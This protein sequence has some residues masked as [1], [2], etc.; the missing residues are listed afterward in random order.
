[1][2][3]QLERREDDVEVGGP[4]PVL[5]PVGQD[6]LLVRMA[7]PIMLVGSGPT[8]RV[9]L[10]GEKVSTVHAA[11]IRDGTIAYVR[12]LASRDGVMVD[13]ESVQECLLSGGE[14]LSVGGFDF[15]FEGVSAGP[16]PPRAPE[17]TL[18]ETVIEGR[19]LLIGH[20]KTCDVVVRGDAGVSTAHALI[21][22][23]SG[24]RYIRDLGSRTGT[25]V[26]GKRVHFEGL[27]HGDVI[28]VGD[29]ELMYG[30]AE[31]LRFQDV[32]EISQTE[33]ATGPLK[34]STTQAGLEGVASDLA[35]VE[36][37]EGV[38]DGKTV[39]VKPAE[40]VSPTREEAGN[41]TVFSRAALDVAPPD[42]VLHGVLAGSEYAMRHD[43][44]PTSSRHFIP[45]APHT[46]PQNANQTGVEDDFEA[47]MGS[48]EVPAANEVA[49]HPTGM[50]EEMEREESFSI[51]MSS[52]MPVGMSETTHQ[53]SIAAVEPDEMAFDFDFTEPE[54]GVAAPGG[55]GDTDATG[56]SKQ[57]RADES[58]ENSDSSSGV[59]PD[60]GEEERVDG[61]RES[62]V[63]NQ[64]D[65]AEP[66]TL[67]S[68]ASPAAIPSAEVARSAADEGA[69]LG[70]ML[71]TGGLIPEPSMD[72]SLDESGEPGAKTSVMKTFAKWVVALSIAGGVGGGT[73]WAM[74]PIKTVRGALEITAAGTL[75][76][77]ALLTGE[78]TAERAIEKLAA[79][80]GAGELG[81]DSELSRWV[82]ATRFEGNL[83]TI[84]VV[85]A[86][87]QAER[88]RALLDVVR[89]RAMKDGKGTPS[90]A[91]LE[92]AV[93]NAEASAKS[94]SEKLAEL[95]RRAGQTEQAAAL[96][97]EITE[98][99]KRRD[100]V[101]GKI[102]TANGGKPETDNDAR[103]KL[104]EA[105]ASFEK[106][107]EAAKAQPE[108]DQRMA[109]FVAAVQ[110]V[111]EQGARLSEEIL[112]R[113]HEHAE[114]LKMLKRRLDERMRIRQQQAWDNDV[115][116]KNLRDQLRQVKLKLE[117]PEKADKA[118]LDDL[119]GEMEYLEGL[120]SARRL[121][122]GSDKGDQRA[123]AE[124]QSIIEEQAHSAE[125]DRRRLGESFEQMRETLARA[126]PEAG[127]V[128]DA[129]RQL[130][131]DLEARLAEL[132]A[133]RAAW[134]DASAGAIS[135]HEQTIK[136]LETELTEV[137]KTMLAISQALDQARSTLPSAEELDHARKAV[138]ESSEE[139][140]KARK[141]IEGGRQAAEV[142]G[143]PEPEVTVI[144][145]ASP[146]RHWYA[147]GAAALAL[148]LLSPIL[149]ARKG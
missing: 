19:T 108:P 3:A 42:D 70:K 125:Q 45:P 37:V 96:A 20:W 59:K 111:Q 87:P 72:S 57:E 58:V 85:G 31:P 55:N 118:I 15:L 23:I 137:E 133:A 105:V 110:N 147:A 142:S 25:R 69:E 32:P 65:K 26:N 54:D 138:S 143:T 75:N 12:D 88:M 24:K 60:A 139:L 71:R 29:T 116:L 49:A 148:T 36:T 109:A 144:A 78:G 74:E 136:S 27:R 40:E 112:A 104:D 80:V 10:R 13:G 51:D 124:V 84:E 127:S 35:P 114:R 97:T 28:A 141:A 122:V 6:G 149:R 8:C 94:T 48:L 2:P 39:V 101:M 5:V 103:T 1:M 100:Q 30:E 135:R 92:E 62:I 44:M 132:Q 89:E 64:A 53:A 86:E 52:D 113:H 126:V 81:E 129:Q 76:P 82:T 146:N 99:E 145:G 21:L 107:L 66:I 63:L 11:L 18:G 22:E 128:P 83:L 121:L 50:T 43:R 47:L 34:L 115:E 119:R 106:Q 123:L 7:R 17:G 93:R 90:M 56:A 68:P 46:P 38:A 131:T 73:W 95:E 9:Q 98:L 14:K 41:A 79:G 61:G 67:E 91:A 102:E 16:M 130:A 117:N 134:T 140:A 120:I 77:T 4:H 33:A